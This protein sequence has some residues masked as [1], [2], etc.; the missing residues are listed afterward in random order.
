MLR[1]S[2]PIALQTIERALAA[3]D[4]TT[5]AETAHALKSSCANLGGRQLAEQL[6]RCEMAARDTGDA[7]EV[8][9]AAAGLQQK[10]AALVA[11]LA[12]VTART[13]GTVKS[14]S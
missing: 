2:A 13:T 5:V 12:Q 10:F 8:R 7:A 14:A 11:A 4:L 6:D 9:R 1:Q 3:G